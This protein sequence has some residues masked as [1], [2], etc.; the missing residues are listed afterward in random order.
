MLCYKGRFWVGPDKEIQRHIISASHNSSLGGHSRF[1]ATYHRVKR[2]FAWL[3]MKSQIQSYIQQC[4]VYQQAKTTPISPLGLLQQ[5]NV[6]DQAWAM[7]LLDFVEGLLR[8]AN[9]TTILI[10][11]DRLSKYAHFIALIHPFMGVQVAN[12][13]INHIFKLHSFLRLLCRIETES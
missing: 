1:Y 9:H 13:Y 2:L 5:L 4:L 6:L 12:L 8:S 11:V 3:G 10:V 7:G